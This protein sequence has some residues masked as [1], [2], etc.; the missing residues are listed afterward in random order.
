M[1]LD[2]PFVENVEMLLDYHSFAIQGLSD[3][4]YGMGVVATVI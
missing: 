1:Q 3:Q 4:G 2:I